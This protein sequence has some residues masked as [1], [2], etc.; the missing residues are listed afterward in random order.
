[1]ADMPAT[2]NI[3][4]GSA[5]EPVFSS[6]ISKIMLF[7]LFIIGLDILFVYKFT[8]LISNSELWF[9]KAY[10]LL[11]GLFLTSRFLIVI[12]YKDSHAATYAAAAYPSISFI[13]AAKNEE[14]SIYKTIEACM[15]SEYPNAM[16]CI[17]VND[18]STDKT[19]QEMN[20][21]AKNFTHVQVINFEKNRGKR[22]G[23]AEGVL[24]STGDVI[25]FVDSDSFVRKH[26]VKHL[27][28]H[29]IQD[30]TIGAVAGN[31]GV[32]NASVNA[33]TKMQSARYGISFDIFKACESVFGTVTCCP[34]CFSA[35]RRELLLKVL[36][37]WRNQMFWGTKSTFGDDRSLTN[38]ILRDWQVIYCRTAYAV[39]IVPERYKTLFK[40][41]LRWKKSWIR[42]GSTAAT[43]MW[44]KNP[45]ASVSFYMNLLLPIF[46]PI[47]VFNAIAVQP[48]FFGHM[49]VT[50]LVGLIFL[51][52][53]YGLFYFW[54]SGNKYWWYVIH[55]T[56]LYVFALVWQ[57]PYAL[58][59]LR[60]TTWG[61]R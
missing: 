25:V 3:A 9:I 56:L 13:I 23:M 41:Q 60:D 4:F 45:V 14:K 28:E 16:E 5:K 44:R 36:P 34:G 48:I 29:F 51:S 57:M 59:K 12:F 53:L 8:L 52:F 22:E 7:G 26:A 24:A 19:L 20:R 61:T 54:Q 33:L 17:V 18:G 32:E 11:T 58:F 6:L 10:I 40:Q 31:S 37:E 27:V 47:V 30:K 35:Y 21:A 43:F 49:P 50:F 1:M 42:E 46:S 15:R 39:T 38:Y 2:P 55:F